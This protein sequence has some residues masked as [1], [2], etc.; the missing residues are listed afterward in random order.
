MLIIQ[1]D[2]F[3]SGLDEEDQRM[4]H[5]RTSAKGTTA[6]DATE[7]PIDI[8]DLGNE[9]WSKIDQN[10]SEYT[11][12]RGNEEDEPYEGRDICLMKIRR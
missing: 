11:R 7:N 5:Y 2:P 4:Y 10:E 6:A 1:E 8:V 12:L 3:A 9:W